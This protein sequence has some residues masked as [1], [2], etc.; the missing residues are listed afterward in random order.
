MRLQ[1]ASAAW[2]LVLLSATA[3]SSIAA[4]QVV[5]SSYSSSYSPLNY[6]IFFSAAAVDRAGNVYFAGSRSTY[7]CH[8]S[9][10]LC[11]ATGSD[12]VIY[13]LSAEGKDLGTFQFG[14]SAADSAS[15]IAVDGD[16]FLYV[17]GRTTSLDFPIQ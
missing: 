9:R 1:P 2:I 13:A 4:V 3:T 16:G 5:P 10:P 11:R 14:G 12:A 17:T 6:W 7:E 8:P 15:G